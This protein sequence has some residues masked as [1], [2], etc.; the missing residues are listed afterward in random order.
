MSEYAQ[1][2][3]IPHE[4][5][6]QNYQVVDAL[7]RGKFNAAMIWSGA[8]SK[9]KLEHPEAEFEMVKGYV[10]PPE[11]RFDNNWGVKEKEVELIQ[12]INEAFAESS[13]AARPGASP[14]A[15][16]CLLSADRKISANRRGRKGRRGKPK[17]RGKHVEVK[18]RAWCQVTT[19]TRFCTLM[20][21]ALVFPLRSLRLCGES[22][23]KDGDHD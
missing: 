10:P 3:G 23:L 16:A 21:F 11:M 17:K 13:R 6:F 8:I 9:A 20:F 1:A 12:F 14:S 18:R 19:D 2:N 5:F 15:T 4:T 7:I 22:L